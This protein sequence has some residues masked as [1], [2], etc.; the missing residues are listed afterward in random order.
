MD[1]LGLKTEEEM[2]ILKEQA[3]KEWEKQVE[4]MREETEQLTNTNQERMMN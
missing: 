4:K 3:E 2:E 1:K